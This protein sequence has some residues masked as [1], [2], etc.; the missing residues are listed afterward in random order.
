MA[1]FKEN[2]SQRIQI[3]LLI[4]GGFRCFAHQ[5]GCHIQCRAHFAGKRTADF[6]AIAMRQTVHILR[7]LQSQET[8]GGQTEIADFHLIA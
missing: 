5:F 7:L 4:I 6:V 8:R 2:N 1:H 3:N